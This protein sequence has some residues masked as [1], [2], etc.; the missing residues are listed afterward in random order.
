MSD[1]PAIELDF[2]H[3]YKELENIVERMERGEQDLENSL[4][5]FERGVALM[6][7]CHGVLKEAEQKVGILVKDNDG[8][9]HTEPFEDSPQG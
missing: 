6:K 3:A 2:E 1:T 7:H 9:F 5:D 8:L 4:N